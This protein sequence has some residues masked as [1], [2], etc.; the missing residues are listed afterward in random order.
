MQQRIHY[1]NMT[2]SARSALIHQLSLETCG[3]NFFDSD[4]GNLLIAHTDSDGVGI[5]VLIGFQS[6]PPRS[7]ALADEEDAMQRENSS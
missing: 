6:S 1:F 7:L 5:G 2:R 3:G 4:S